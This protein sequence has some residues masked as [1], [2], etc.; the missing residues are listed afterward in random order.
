MAFIYNLTDVWNAAGTAFAAI[1]MNVT[2]TAS[3]AA[4][5]LLDLQI[6]GVSLFNVDKTGQ[7]QV[8]AGTITAPAVSPIGDD[9]TGVW[10]PAA[11]TVAVSTGGSERMRVV[12]G[13]NVGIGTNNPGAKLHV[14]G[15]DIRIKNGTGVPYF[16]MAGRSSD[17]QA[18]FAFQDNGTTANNATLTAFTNILTVGTANSER[19]RF[20]ASGNVLL[21]TVTSPSTGT[22]CFTIETGTAPTATPAD[23]LTLYSSD[24]SAGNT[25]PS[26]YTEG[27]AIVGTG[28]P[29]ADR[30]IAIRINGT[31][32]YLLASTIP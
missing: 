16:V 5:K 4:S 2:N 7:V 9:N 10:F 22:Q 12:S 6:G 18:Q 1:K 26:V 13:G 14:E 27:T 8:S 32:Y 3:A 19:L 29:T 15:A 25:I 21:G 20:D 30:T 11:D 17:G 24:L 23:T 31:V 28:T